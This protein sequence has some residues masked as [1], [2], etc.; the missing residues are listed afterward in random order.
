M[1]WTLRG[2]RS[3]ITAVGTMAVAVATVTLVPVLAQEEPGPAPEP[4]VELMTSFSAANQYV[5]FVDGDPATSDPQQGFTSLTPWT[6]SGEPE[7]ITVGATADPQT[8]LAG[9][10][11]LD[12]GGQPIGPLPTVAPAHFIQPPYGW[13]GALPLIG[14]T[15]YQCA[16]GRLRS[17][18][19]AV[20]PRS[21]LARPSTS[22][23]VPT[24]RSTSGG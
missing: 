11:C 3:R 14:V 5:R 20:E 1:T 4:Y 6:L 19:T 9:T 12:P 2:R 17:F 10:A 8:V 18:P 13:I 16:S 15:S 22:L 24:C 21:A 23:A 7:L